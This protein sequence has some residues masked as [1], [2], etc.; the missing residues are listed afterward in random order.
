[1]AKLRGSPTTARPAATAL[2]LPGW[3]TGAKITDMDGL[4]M[5]Q[6]MSKPFM[7][8]AVEGEGAR[9]TKTQTN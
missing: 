8:K 4:D 5:G 3:I 7:T 6:N 2:S 1:M 9:K